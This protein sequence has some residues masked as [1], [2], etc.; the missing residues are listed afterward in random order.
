ME[1]AQNL[2]SGSKKLV[3]CPVLVDFMTNEAQEKFAAYPERLYIVQKGKIVYQGQRGPFDY[4]I[5]EMIDVLKS[6]I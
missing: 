6:L 3:T 1:A 5:Q 2:V 4:D